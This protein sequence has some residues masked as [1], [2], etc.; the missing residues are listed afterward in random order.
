ML[1]GTPYVRTFSGRLGD[2]NLVEDGA[3]AWFKLEI[4]ILKNLWN[5]VQNVEEGNSVRT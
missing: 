3:D 1:R 4:F 2:I 5:I